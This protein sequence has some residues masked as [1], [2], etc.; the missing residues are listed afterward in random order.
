MAYPFTRK[1]QSRYPQQPQEPDM[2]DA[3]GNGYPDAFESEEARVMAQIAE[4]RKAFMQKARIAEEE[5][6]SM[7]PSYTGDGD[8]Q[9]VIDNLLR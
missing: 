8:D 5:F 3:N 1:R 9:S 6:T 2:T 4:R 7:N